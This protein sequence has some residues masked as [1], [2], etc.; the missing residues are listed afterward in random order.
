MT[1]KKRILPALLTSL[2]AAFGAAQ[3]QAA[4]FSNVVVFGDSLS[5][6]GYY[7][8]FLAGIGLPASQMGRFTTNPDPVWS[9]LVSQFY[10]VTG[11]PSNAGGSIYAQGGARVASTPGITPPGQAERPVST[12][13]TEYLAAHGGAADPGALYTMWAGANDFF[14]N[15]SALQAGAITPAQF[16]SNVLGAAAAEVGQV[17]RLYAAGARNVMV[18]TGFDGAL[19]PGL[20]AADAATRAAVTQLTVGYNTTLLT[21]LA[22]SGLRVIPV[23]LFSLFNE[24]RANP[25][26]F[27]FSN[28][29]GVA[30]GPLPPASSSSSALFCLQGLN[31]AAGTQN[32][33]LWADP[34]G[35]M[36]TAG[37]R[38]VA[39]F[40]E[41]LIEGPYNY[42]MLAEAPIRTRMLHVQGVAEGLSNGSGAEPGKFTAFVA[43]GG[44]RFGVDNTGA[45]NVGVSNSNDS[46]T[47]GLT[48]R[49]SDTVTVG[50][51]VGQT[52]GRGTFGNNQG[53]Y[54]SSETDWS[55]F[56]AVR[57]GHFYADGIGTIANISY[58]DIHRNITLGA[59]NRQ[60]T[61][62]TKGSNG[63]V[64]LNAGYDFAIG[65]F[66]VGPVVS[67]S[68]QNI[69]VAAFDEA[70]AGSSNLRIFTQNRNSQVW[71]GGLKAS[72]DFEG[73]TPWIRFTAD[74]ETENDPRYVTATPISIA[75]GNS[76]D[77]L[78]YA[79]D[80]SYTTL[81]AGLRG[82]FA[83]NVGWG[84]SYYKVSGRSGVSEWGAAGA[85]TYKF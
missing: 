77:I 33:L 55:L 59:L 50:A 61:A 43:G 26:S 4:D 8:G 6:A 25:G 18:F 46:Y 31:V 54:R 42:G 10:G 17:G 14:V 45:N 12:Q 20:A 53:D 66:L 40:A 73:F 65:R 56:A 5:D 68:W 71:S 9:E 11:K 75:S 28:I 15:F 36:T 67:A 24:I 83:K 63:S 78:A 60:A 44:G 23:D 52:R 39:Q 13:V 85:L 3:A 37:N 41:G 16:Q 30:C 29:T 72:M 27:G 69:E 38:I 47:L 32:T 49:A 35:H 64:F 80:T 57:M 7:R 82:N 48:V 58:N 51:A 22:S 74:K 84:V 70:G 79:P 62:N 34:T 81:M 76:Y 2:F 19:T 21:G 1:T